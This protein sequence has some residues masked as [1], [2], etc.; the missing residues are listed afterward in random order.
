MELSK[1]PKVSSNCKSKDDL[2]YLT[3]HKVAEIIKCE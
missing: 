2:E 3:G 1:Q